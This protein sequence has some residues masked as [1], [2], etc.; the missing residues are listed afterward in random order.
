MPPKRRVVELSPCRNDSKSEAARSGGMPIPVSR[1]VTSSST[2]VP[3][4]TAPVGARA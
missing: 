2:V 3:G 4:A 1:T